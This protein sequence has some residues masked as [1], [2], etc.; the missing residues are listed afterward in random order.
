VLFA[1]F[2]NSVISQI[3]DVPRDQPSQLNL[4]RTSV[5]CD[6]SGQKLLKCLMNSQNSS[7]DRMLEQEQDA[8]VSIYTYITHNIMS[9]A[10]LACAVNSMYSE[11]NGY[12]F[13]ILVAGDTDM[14]ESRDPRW[15]KVKILIDAMDNTDDALTQYFVWIDADMIILDMGVKM[16]EIG[17][18][19][20]AA[21]ILL[22]HDMILNSPTDS[23][24]DIPPGQVNSG[25]IFVRNTPWAREV[26]MKWWNDYERSRMS[27]QSAF[28]LMFNTMTAQA[29]SKLEILRPDALN[30]LFPAWLNQQPSNQFL[31]LAGESDVYREEVFG[32]ALNALC[33]STTSSSR[34][35][36]TVDVDV[37]V[38]G[39]KPSQSTPLPR[40]L[41]LSREVLFHEWSVLDSHRVARLTTLLEDF[42]ALQEEFRQ[43]S[44]KKKVRVIEEYE[45][46]VEASCSGIHNIL[47]NSANEEN[48]KRHRNERNE[49]LDKVTI[50]LKKLCFDSYSD[51][52][53]TRE[54]IHIASSTT[55]K[56][57]TKESIDA[58]IVIAEKFRAAMSSGYDLINFASEMNMYSSP[59]VKDKFFAEKDIFSLLD[60]IGNELLPKLKHHLPSSLVHRGMY[61][62]FKYYE[63]LS[64]ALTEYERGDDVMDSLAKAIS[65]W[66]TLHQ[67][68]EYYGSDYYSVDRL[69]EGWN[70][71]AKYGLMACSEASGLLTQLGVDSLKD[72][73]KL[74]ETTFED[75]E[76]NALATQ[77]LKSSVAMDLSVTLANCGLCTHQLNVESVPESNVK[78]KIINL[79]KSRKL[80]QQSQ[81]YLQYSG[82]QSQPQQEEYIAARLA[83]VTEEIIAIEVEGAATVDHDKHHGRQGEKKTKTKKTV[84]KMMRKRKS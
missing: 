28:L 69:R 20:P 72:S 56:A 27:D 54:D 29:R 37:D 46:Y 78:E 2:C 44:K 18:Q 43:R 76:E 3:L 12:K 31:H 83:A 7:H 33:S 47:K 77:Q 39:N 66:R 60:E 4:P 79:K 75:L 6:M 45:E 68:Y 14:Y 64:I 40:Q 13:N 57:K 38:D 17:K 58:D 19:Y 30:T 49:D 23:S 22:S 5:C 35:E 51:I 63:F 50:D 67:E 74:L 24:S 59:N 10:A 48:E 8:K 65:V 52:A 32:L 41:G 84:K 82:V 26:L 61:Y 62:E 16:E 25:L 71:Y 1:L 42:T 21:D 81:H 70:I 80:L 36:V 53:K 55:E 11:G 73:I 15:N 9:Y 34:G